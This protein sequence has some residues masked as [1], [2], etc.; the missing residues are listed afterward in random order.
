V[1]SRAVWALS[2]RDRGQSLG[3][4]ARAIVP[5]GVLGIVYPDER[6]AVGIFVYRNGRG[7]WSAFPS[8]ATEIE[9]SVD[10]PRVMAVGERA[11]FV[12]EDGARTWR[13]VR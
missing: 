2:E 9:V 4:V 5:G 11:S 6:P 13:I 3:L 1:R 8:D 7:Y 10:W 12:S